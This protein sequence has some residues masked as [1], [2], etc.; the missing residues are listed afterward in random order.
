VIALRQLQRHDESL[1][2]LDDALELYPMTGEEI[3]ASS[4]R[5]PEAFLEIWKEDAELGRELGVRVGENLGE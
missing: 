2:A 4:S 3:A 1:A 5:I